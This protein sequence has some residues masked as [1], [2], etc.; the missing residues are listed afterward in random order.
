MKKITVFNRTLFTPAIAAIAL[1]SAPRCTTNIAGGGGSEAGNARIIGMVTNEHG[2]P[3]ENV[4]VTLLSSDYDPQKDAPPA[5][6]C[7]DTTAVDGRYRFL[8]VKGRTYSIEAAQ[9]S[10]RLR[11][12]ATDVQ[13]VTTVDTVAS[14]SLKPPGTIRVLLSDILVS[15][16]GYLYIPGTTVSTRLNETDCAALLDPVP[17]G[18]I[19]SVYYRSTDEPEPVVIRNSV[20][21]VSGDTVTIP[22]QGWNYSQKLVL[23]TSVSGAD[24]QEDAYGFPVLV[25]LSTTNFDF[26]QAKTGGEDI[27]FTSSAGTPLP[28]EIEQWDYEDQRAAIWVR[29]DTV[30]GNDSTQSIMMHWGNP[31]AT[32][33]SNSAAVFDTEDGFQGVWHLGE[34]GSTEVSDAT[35][36]HYHGTP[37]GMS[38]ASAVDGMIGNSQSFNGTS[39]YIELTGTAQSRLN[40]PENGNYTLSAWVFA[41][42]IDSAAHYIIS[43]SNRNYNLDL[44]GRDLWEI[45]DLRSAVGWESNFAEAQSGEW[46]Y[47]TG[48]RS[49]NVMQLYVDG[50]C[51]DSTIDTTASSSHRDS[52]FDVHIGKRAES[53]YGYW[54]GMIDE[55][56]ISDS[57]RSADW[58]KL[59]YMNQKKEDRLIVFR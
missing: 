40:I 2:A 42:A 28:Y 44:S 47:L 8:V 46:K 41:A 52:T 24:V 25:R 11:G 19:P 32:D 37:Y 7:I 17:A 3:E 13:A 1:L 38:A 39:S 33:V 10:S 59:C 57:S 54:C 22:W 30:R 29:V 45:Y 56:N 58:I 49:G 43:K 55:V 4:I 35:G 14:F 26:T 50:E 18:V 12:L 15:E 6:S 36:N 51:A 23:N 16:T 5:D 20:E 27:R 21:V 34:A 48:V 31:G 53:D 9:I